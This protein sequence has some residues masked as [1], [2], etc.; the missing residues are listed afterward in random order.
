M[1]NGEYVKPI[2]VVPDHVR[3]TWEQENWSR[4]LRNWVLD[5]VPMEI[6]VVGNGK[7]KGKKIVTY[8]CE[9]HSK[10]LLLPCLLFLLLLLFASCLSSFIR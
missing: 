6:E 8:V 9:P 10:S 7:R 3:R 1:E 4:E 5:W 2:E